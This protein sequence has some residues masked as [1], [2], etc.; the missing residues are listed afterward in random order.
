MLKQINQDWH[1][2][3]PLQSDEELLKVRFILFKYRKASLA[4]NEWDPKQ[5]ILL[6][7]CIM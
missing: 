7:F 6:K 3:N 1:N 4:I 5:D 2:I